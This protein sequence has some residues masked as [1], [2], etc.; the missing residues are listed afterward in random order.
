MKIN[1]QMP[2]LAHIKRHIVQHTVT[3]LSFYLM[4]LFGNELKSPLL[5]L[6]AELYYNKP[7]PITGT[8]SPQSGLKQE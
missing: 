8:S 3:K 5:F 7:L 2:G 4:V 1:K 6:K